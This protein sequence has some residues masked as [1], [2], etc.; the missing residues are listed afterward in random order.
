MN[1]ISKM[2]AS[3]GG[4]VYRSHS[5]ELRERG[6]R[7]AALLVGNGL[8]PAHK[9]KR[10]VSF[11][12]DHGFF[13][14]SL[15]LAFGSSNAPRVRLGA[16]RDAIASFA[17]SAKPIGLPLYLVASSFSASALLPVA[18]DMEG[19]AAVAFVSPIVEFPPPKLKSALF[20]LPTARLAVGPELL[21][22]RPELLEGL[23]EGVSVLKF[24]K[25]DLETLAADVSR[26]LE[27]PFGIPV[28]VFA[29]EEDPFLSQLGFQALSRA[30]AKVHSYPGVRREPGRDRLADDFYADFGFFLDEVEAG[31]IQ[32]R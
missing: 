9:E 32:G 17:K 12:L 24:R 21:S 27:K 14:F 6:N 28:A 30:G 11:L 18:A 26:A 7:R 16:F 19:I 2:F 29:G 10:L 31:K 20:F 25:R 4:R 8:W 13:V 22:G 15:D 5:W 3:S 1:H 23:A